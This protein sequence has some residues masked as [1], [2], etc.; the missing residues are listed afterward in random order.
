[1][2]AD[3]PRAF[4]AFLAVAQLGVERL[5][6]QR[7]FQLVKRALA[8]IGNHAPDCLANGD[9]LALHGELSWQLDNATSA[10]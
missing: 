3:D 5:R 1:M 10:R 6:F 7:A 2:R 8:F 9:L 4:E